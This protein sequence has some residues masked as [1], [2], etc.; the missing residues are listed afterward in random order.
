MN[1]TE[2]VYIYIEREW[3]TVWMNELNRESEE[4]GAKER[5]IEK[6]SEQHRIHAKL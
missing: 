3:A 2:N 6:M 5:W 1:W 4:V